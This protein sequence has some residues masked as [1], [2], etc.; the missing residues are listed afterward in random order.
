MPNGETVWLSIS[1]RPVFDGDGNFTGYRGTGSDITDEKRIE[2]RLRESEQRLQAIMNYIP[3]ALFLKDS[4]ARYLLINRQFQD[5]FGV[6]PETVVGKSAYDLYPKE[7]ADRYVEGDRAILENW[8]VTSDTVEIPISSGET[9]T[10]TLTK[11]P[12][13]D[14]D[15]GVGFGGVMVDITE[16]ARAEA[17]LKQL[18]GLVADTAEELERSNAE[19]EQ[20]AYVA[21]HDL[22]EPL[23]MVASYCQLLQRRYQGR[24]DTQADEFIGYAVDG[25]TRMQSLINDLLDYS[26]V[27]RGEQSPEE[28][29]LAAIFATLQHDLGKTIEETRASV[30]ADP[31]PVVVGN[32]TQLR[33]LLQNLLTN[34]IKFHG[35]AP[36]AIHVSVK[37]DGEDW[38]F[39]VH[40]NGIGIDPEYAERIFLIFQRLHRRDEYSGTGIG[41]AVCKKI[42]ERHNGRIWFESDG[43]DGTTFYFTL[44]AQPRED[45]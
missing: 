3:T 41:L 27:G 16:R 2:D 12:I 14:G 7:R 1:G 6:D 38:V 35:E 39:S 20:F 15:R 31:L 42:V 36:P 26:R 18:F 44:P 30:T 19:F 5:W 33:Q 11:F 17:E 32:K 21:S 8:E 23:R 10:F 29:D 34:A 4:D 22:Q 9:K 40:D 13:F 43:N 45:A 24:L 37:T 28:V 25:A